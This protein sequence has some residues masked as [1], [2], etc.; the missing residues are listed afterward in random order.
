M[1]ITDDLERRVVDNA[2]GER[3]IV[4]LFVTAIDKA[5]PVHLHSLDSNT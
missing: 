2:E 5:A 4:H 1:L 3:K